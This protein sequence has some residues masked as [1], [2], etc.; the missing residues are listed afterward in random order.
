MATIIVNSTTITL[1]AAGAAAVAASQA[2]TTAADAAAHAAAVPAAVT[3]LQLRR[4]LRAAGILDSANAVIAG[5]GADAVE[6]WQYAGIFERNGPFILAAASAASL[7]SGQIDALF[8]DA[9][10]R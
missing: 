1:D 7:T 10:Q 4:A 9:A 6:T 5:M 2:A 8:R 3:G